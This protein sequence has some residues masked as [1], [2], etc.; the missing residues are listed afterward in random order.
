[1][2]KPTTF[3]EC[4]AAM[5]PEARAA[6][7]TLRRRVH[8]LAPDAVECVSYGLPAFK[9]HGKGLVAFGGWKEH[10]SLYPMSGRVLSELSADLAKYEVEKG[11]VR[12]PPAKPLPVALLKKILKVRT[13]EIAAKVMP[14]PSDVEAWM[15]S[16]KSAPRREKIERLRAIVRSVHP[17]IVEGV[18]WNSP[19]YRT[20]EWFATINTHGPRSLRLILHAGAK[21]GATMTVPDPKGLL[22]LLG[23][24]RA[25]V[26]FT[27]L[28]DLESKA[29]AVKMLVKAW[30]A[31]LPKGASA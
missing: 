11:T 28:D 8:A 26:E 16:V 23:P 1:M 22:K 21:K 31:R 12:F 2:K 7:E 19:S 5:T 24:D 18:K 10:C 25:L 3:D 27:S 13:D 30:I 4:L 15:K 29:A 20:T 14:K 6:L 9:L 17:S